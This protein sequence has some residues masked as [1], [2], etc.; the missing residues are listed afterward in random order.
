VELS[1]TTFRRVKE[2]MI[3][4]GKR[5]TDSKERDVNCHCTAEDVSKMR[6]LHTS[7]LMRDESPDSRGSVIL[8]DEYLCPHGNRF[9]RTKSL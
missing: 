1:W 5:M 2:K 7:D 4:D 9:L 6:F 8:Q 3:M